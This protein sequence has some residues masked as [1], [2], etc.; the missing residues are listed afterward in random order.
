MSIQQPQ[1]GHFV[2]RRPIIFDDQRVTIKLSL[3]V[4]KNAYI[5]NRIIF[6]DLFSKYYRQQPILVV[7]HDG[8]NM[9]Q[10]GFMAL[11]EELQEI[12]KISNEKIIFN[13]VIPPLPKYKHLA[14]PP[15]FFNAVGFQML[16]IENFDIE[17]SKFVGAL[18]A[19]RFSV[20]R[21]RVLYEL[22]Q[23][24]PGDTYLTFNT[25]A[26]L[27]NSM[28]T[29]HSGNYNSEIEWVRNKVFDEPGIQLQQAGGTL[30]GIV[31]SAHTAKIQDRYAIEVVM[32]TDDYA[33]NWFTEKT[34]RL[35]ATGKPFVLMSGKGALGNLCEMGF[36]SFNSA[37][38]ESYDQELTPTFRLAKIIQSLT[39]LHQDT[40]RNKLIK[41][42]YS[43]AKKNRE[44]YQEYVQSKIQLP[45]YS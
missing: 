21:L 35:L 45:T 28:F 5:G 16:P 33:N 17:N 25:T 12:F 27:I 23:H 8:E 11:I 29:G 2:D 1:G 41:K 14:V 39:A 34:G 13:T 38:D 44:L 30:N 24:F 20:M 26:D 15:T 7:G 4:N 43:I 22:D 9:Y 31:A 10:S 3:I 42:M 40:H 36:Q 37:I 6:Y 19:S 18:A 32:E